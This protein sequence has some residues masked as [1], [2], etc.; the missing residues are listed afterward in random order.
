MPYKIVL[1]Y[2]YSNWSTCL[3]YLFTYSLIHSME[4]SPSWQANQFPVTQEITCILW[5]LKVHYHVYKSL[6]P[7]PVLSLINP[8]HASPSHFL[9]NHLATHKHSCAHTLASS[10]D[11]C[12][13]SF[14]WSCF[15][16]KYIWYLWYFWLW[17]NMADVVDGGICCS[18]FLVNSKG[19]NDVSTC[20]RCRNY[21]NLLKEALD[22]LNS[23]QMIN[24]FLQRN[25]WHIWHLRA[26]G[27]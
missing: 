8:V 17:W 6:Q 22:E 24:R 9:M 5:N 18:Q 21:E 23:I 11:F 13:K 27:G 26:H 10:N 15:F 25:C 14:A 16:S 7:D 20:K 1:S 2:I 19:D 4:Q 3:T 12:S